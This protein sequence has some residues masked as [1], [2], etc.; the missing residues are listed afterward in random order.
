MLQYIKVTFQSNFAHF[1]PYFLSIRLFSVLNVPSR[2]IIVL[3]KLAKSWEVGQPF[4]TL[5]EALQTQYF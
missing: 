2:Q 5:S 1:W 3:L 4:T